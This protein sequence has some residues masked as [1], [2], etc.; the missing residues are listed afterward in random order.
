MKVHER[1]QKYIREAGLK[2]YVVAEK[3]GF[4]AKQFSAM[5]TGRRK[6]YADDI[7]K[8]CAALKVP[9]DTFIVPKAKNQT[10]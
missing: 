6:I 4:N 10:T 3:A 2:Q 7:E 8:I 5:M 9:P 1:I